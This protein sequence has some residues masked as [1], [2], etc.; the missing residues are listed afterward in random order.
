MCCLL[1]DDE[2]KI[3]EIIGRWIKA[4][5]H[6]YDLADCSE[7]ARELLKTRTY[8]Y[9][10]I[11]VKL[12]VDDTDHD[13]DSSTGRGLL[14]EI[15]HEYPGLPVLMMTAHEKDPEFSAE[16]IEI[17]ARGF[18]LKGSGSHKF[19][20]KV[21]AILRGT[22]RS[23]SPET[24]EPPA[25]ASPTYELLIDENEANLMVLQGKEIDLTRTE[26][27]FMCFMSRNPRKRLPTE[28]I[29]RTVW[30]GGPDGGPQDQRIPSVK[31]GIHKKIKAKLRHYDT[32]KFIR[33]IRGA[34][35]WML[36]IA[37]TK[38]RFIPKTAT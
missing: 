9:C 1:V 8:D 18:I 5:G 24:A 10:A 38:V 25:P 35:C 15:C 30:S 2:P 37:P 23:R 6:T 26:F 33:V 7:K 13:P 27:N 11:D 17:G 3:S 16:L 28:R 14:K 34:G 36:D 20:Q 31:D 4:M 29:I 21:E 12:K 19:Q 22:T 32:S